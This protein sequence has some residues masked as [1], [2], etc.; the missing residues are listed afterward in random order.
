METR[1]KIGFILIL[2]GIILISYS[3]FVF[4]FLPNALLNDVLDG[5][6]FTGSTIT[7]VTMINC[8]DGY[9]E[10][11]VDGLNLESIPACFS[12]IYIDP[13]DDRSLLLCGD[14]FVDSQGMVQR[15][16]CTVVQ[17]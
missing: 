8:P 6:E 17:P 1:S 2:I 4:V 12:N 10:G 5:S 15:V 13:F 9:S 7:T 14:S 11:H 3:F 16:E